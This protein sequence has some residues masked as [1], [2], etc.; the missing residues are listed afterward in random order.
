MTA[1]TN[2]ERYRV[3]KMAEEVRRSVHTHG[4]VGISA[5]NYGLEPTAQTVAALARQL[6]GIAVEN[7][8]GPLGYIHFRVKE[9]AK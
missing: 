6:P 2:S 4:N 7:H 3:K 8:G 1:L 9:P 5:W